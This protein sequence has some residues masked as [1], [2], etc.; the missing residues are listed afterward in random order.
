[1]LPGSPDPVSRP[2]SPKK[3]PGTRCPSSVT[4]P[5]IAADH[6]DHA[7]AEDHQRRQHRALFGQDLAFPE[8]AAGHGLG[9][10]IL[11][12]VGHRGE[13]CDGVEHAPRRDVWP[14]AARPRRATIAKAGASSDGESAR[15]AALAWR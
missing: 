9:E 5:V 4:P 12:V 14:I 1:M 10:R 6:R 8:G 11:L 15:P 2:P 7:A 3:S 13:Q